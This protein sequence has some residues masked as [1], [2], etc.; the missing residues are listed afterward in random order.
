MAKAR[1]MKNQNSFW[2]SEENSYE[3]DISKR[4]GKTH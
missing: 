3:H 4:Y 1:S 2:K